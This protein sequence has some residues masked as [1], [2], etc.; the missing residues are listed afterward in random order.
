MLIKSI[1]WK[2]FQ[3]SKTKILPKV[4]LQQRNLIC[5]GSSM[6]GRRDQMEDELT[7]NTCIPAFRGYSFF[8]VYDGHSGT[9]TAKYISKNLYHN[10]FKKIHEIGEDN[11]EKAI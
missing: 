4:I 11:I 7:V 2:L 8:G 1:T 9:R 10:I 6:L 3:Q 5:A